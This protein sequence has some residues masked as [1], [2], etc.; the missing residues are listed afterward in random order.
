MKV[1]WYL[2]GA[3]VIAA[4]GVA[5]VDYF[6]TEPEPA[7]TYPLDDKRQNRLAGVETTT[8]ETPP[9]M[10]S[11]PISQDTQLSMPMAALP[12]SAATVLTPAA[13]ISATQA[14]MPIKRCM[15]MSSMEAPNEGDWYNYKIRKQDLREVANAG[16][17]TIRMP[18]RVSEHTALSAPYTIDPVLLARMD[19][20]VS[21]GL[22]YGLQVIVDVHH[23]VELNE[24]A[25]THEPRLE[26]IW[27]QLARHY[28]SAPPAVI[29]EL[30]NEP[31]D[32]MT[33]KRTDA[34][35]R[36]LLARVRQ[37]NPNRWVIVG[38]AEWGTLGGLLKSNPP[39]DPKIISTFHTYEPFKYTHQGAEW[40][41]P[42]LPMGV[43][44]GTKKDMDSIA[45]NFRKAKKWGQ[46]HGNPILLG[47]FGVNDKLPTHERA[48]WTRHVRMT[49][50]VN[51]MGWCYWDMMGGF[52]VWDRDVEAWI[53][54]IKNAL[55][56]TP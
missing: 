48:R 3:A 8:P 33:V 7:L 24:D 19:E 25:D 53:K 2:A 51:D 27:D 36:R 41:D 42:P 5:A 44:W 9:T 37:D 40:M 30:I 47:E 54:P 11:A 49:A 26:A 1:L 12:K 56:P 20:V 22:E 34:L 45:K 52:N 14:A 10:Q 31:F 32:D 39:K 38:S 4:G 43:T 17:D 18:V 13:Q 6:T 35:N 50:E 21:W 29:F 46:K 15:N 16:F 28:A 55:I 23:Y